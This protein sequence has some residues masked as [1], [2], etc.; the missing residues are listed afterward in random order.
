[1]V[2]STDIGLPDAAA[3]DLAVKA[4]D[5]SCHTL[6]AAP[7]IGVHKTVDGGD[8]WT[9]F[10]AGLPNLSVRS[11]CLSSDC[12]YLCISTYGRGVWEVDLGDRRS[13]LSRMVQN[14]GLMPAVSL[15]RAPN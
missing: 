14:G 1:M 10:G 5:R 6:Y 4:R 9:L 12:E 13:G 7:D 3:S 2:K 15:P 11:H 8:N